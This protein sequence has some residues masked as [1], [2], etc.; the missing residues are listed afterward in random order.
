MKIGIF[1][2]LK[3]FILFNLLKINKIEIIR[4]SLNI[5]RKKL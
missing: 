3:I 2:V 4:K 1:F 5:K